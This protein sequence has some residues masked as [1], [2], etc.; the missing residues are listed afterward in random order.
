MALQAGL[1]IGFSKGGSGGGGVNGAGG[2]YLA[3][4]LDD[5]PDGL[6]GG[7]TSFA[8]GDTVY[9]FVFHS[10]DVAIA[11]VT[12]S[13]GSVY[14]E[15]LSIGGDGAER[16]PR[17]IEIPFVNTDRATLPLP[18]LAILS[19]EWLGRSLGGLRLIDER[20]VEVAAP[21]VGVARAVINTRGWPF[22][23][24]T[25]ALVLEA[26]ENYPIIVHILGEYV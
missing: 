6:N 5:R 17:T 2:G 16:L 15:F 14:Q 4:E 10:D 25:P 9:F 26:D 19:H 13:A 22:R 1:S 18:A 23:L 12:A 7:R 8:P 20:T 3:A 11:A 21:G 24:V